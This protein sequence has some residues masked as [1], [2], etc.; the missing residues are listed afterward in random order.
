LDA[1]NILKREE[2]TRCPAAAALDRLIR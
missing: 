2:E 1:V